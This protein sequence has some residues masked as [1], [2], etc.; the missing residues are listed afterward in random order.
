MPAT[1]AASRIDG[2][3]AGTL[4]R[5]AGARCVAYV[6][7]RPALPAGMTV[8]DYVLLGPHAPHRATS[9]SRAA[10]IARW[11]AGLLAR[12]DLRPGWPT[13]PL[14][15]CPAARCSGS[16]S[17]RALAQE[18]PVL[19][20]DEPTSALDIGHEQQ[21]LELIDELRVE[22][23]LTV[24]TAMHDLTLAGQFADRLVHA[25]RRGD[26]RQGPASEV[27]TEAPSRS[28]TAPRCASPRRARHLVVVPTRRGVPRMT[29]TA[30][31]EDP[32]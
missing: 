24:V 8:A 17:R 2:D 9:A 27:L 6:P 11:S 4:G 30:T 7:Q 5:E 26:R 32:R 31:T 12:L 10:A 14:G 21:V 23:D 13:G 20:L 28:T 22:Q 18:A 25:G 16:C 29:E 15:R 19:L 3:R 1:R